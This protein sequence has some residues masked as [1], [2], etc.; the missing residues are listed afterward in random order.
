LLTTTTRSSLPY[1]VKAYCTGSCTILRS[2]RGRVRL[3]VGLVKT[4]KTQRSCKAEVSTTNEEGIKG[5]EISLILNHCFMASMSNFT[6]YAWASCCLDNGWVGNYGAGTKVEE[7]PLH[8]EQPVQERV[9]FPFLSFS[10][11]VTRRRL[12]ELEYCRCGPQFFIWITCFLPRVTRGY[13]PRV[14]LLNGPWISW[15]AAREKNACYGLLRIIWNFLTLVIEFPAFS[16]VH[17][18]Q[19]MTLLLALFGKWMHQV[20]R[21]SIFATS[22]FVDLDFE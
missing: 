7:E 9:L 21:L 11:K 6:H 2:R 8:V 1:R 20:P 10:G 14:L 16:L 15:E 4:M 3:R 5:R 13:F 19:V 12:H 18:W 17:T 22:R